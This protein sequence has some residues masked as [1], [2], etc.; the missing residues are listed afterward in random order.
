MAAL[1]VVTFFL[2]YQK[3]R[4]MEGLV[5]MK[6]LLI[7]TLPLLFFAFV[8]ASFIQVLVPASV[9]ERWIGAESGLK[10]ILVASLAGGFLPGGPYVTLPLIVGLAKVGASLP[11]LVS[12]IT[13][14]S[15]IAVAR[16]PLEIGILGPKLTFL[17]LASVLVLSPLAGL[18]AL[19]ITKLLKIN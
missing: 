10:G 17:R 9:L 15:L 19:G 18:I 8:L 12:M 14:W 11:V 13:G 3:D 16:L 7:Q 2:A 6:N 5:I 1:S 4:H